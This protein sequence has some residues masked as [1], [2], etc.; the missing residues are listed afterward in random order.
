MT[1]CAETRNVLACLVCIS[2]HHALEH[3][4]RLRRGV[5]HAL[6]CS[7]CGSDGIRVA[8]HM[9]SHHD[10]SVQPQHVHAR[11]AGPSSRT[12]AAWG[13]YRL[14]RGATALLQRTAGVARRITASA[15]GLLR[16]WG[17]GGVAAV[18]DS[19]RAQA[20]AG[21]RSRWSQQLLADGSAGETRGLGAAM[22]AGH[23]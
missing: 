18:A 11:S 2:R 14:A 20:A 8:P 23:C 22:C 5:G 9:Q 13:W 16:M 1:G 6:A 3:A 21:R 15:G 4:C 10:G 7:M 17:A 12:G 19:A